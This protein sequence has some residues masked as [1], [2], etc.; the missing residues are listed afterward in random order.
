VIELGRELARPLEV[1][2]NRRQLLG[3]EALNACTMSIRR[4]LERRQRLFLCHDADVARVGTIEVTAMQLAEHVEPRLQRVAQLRRQRYPYAR[5]KLLQIR[6]GGNSLAQRRFGETA[7]GGRTAA[8]CSEPARRDF[9][10]RALRNGDEELLLGRRRRNQRWPLGRRPAGA[11]R[12]AGNRPVLDTLAPGAEEQGSE[13]QRG[14]QRT[15]RGPDDGIHIRYLASGMPHERVGG[16]PS[17]KDR[18]TQ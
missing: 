17:R 14:D 5:R 11:N 6:V 3:S 10:Q 4:T 1:L 2:A 8:G 9:E 12:I 7:D 13:R 15:K 16:C 18:M